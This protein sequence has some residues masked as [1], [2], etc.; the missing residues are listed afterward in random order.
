MK[1]LVLVLAMS[2]ASNALA[3]TNLYTIA[4]LTNVAGLSSNALFE[5][6]LGGA[7]SRH[8]SYGQLAAQI[9]TNLSTGG[10]SNL[11]AGQT[12]IADAT[13]GNDTTGTRGDLAKPWQTLRAVTNAQAGD[14][15]KLRPGAYVLTDP[16]TVPNGATIQGDGL[17]SST[18]TNRLARDMFAPFT[19][20]AA[21]VIGSHA[22][23]RDVTIVGE[24]YAGAPA[25]Y[26]LQ[27]APPIGF[28]GLPSGVDP[29]PATNFVLHSVRTLDGTT[30]LYLRHSNAWSGAI[31]DCEFRAKKTGATL[32]TGGDS[33]SNHL[34][35]F[36]TIFAAIGPNLNTNES[37]NY[38]ADGMKLTAAGTFYFQ[39]C[40][41]V[42]ANPRPV[43]VGGIPVGDP[44][45]NVTNATAAFLRNSNATIYFVG[46]TF[47]SQNTNTD[48]STSYDIFNDTNSTAGPA[49]VFLIGC[50]YDR[51]KVSGPVYDLTFSN[52]FAGS[53]SGVMFPSNITFTTS[54][55]SITDTNGAARLNANNGA[56]QLRVPKMDGTTDSIA[57]FITSSLTGTTKLQSW[58]TNTQIYTLL[59]NGNSNGVFILNPAG[60]GSG[61]T[62]TCDLTGGTGI[63]ITSAAN[64]RGGTI[65]TS[66]LGSGSTNV[67]I[68]WA[69]STNGL[70]TNFP[71]VAVDIT[72]GVY[73]MSVNHVCT[74][75]DNVGGVALVKVEVVGR[76]LLDAWTLNSGDHGILEWSPYALNASSWESGA[77]P[78]S[79]A[80]FFL[81][82]NTLAFNFSV[83]NANEEDSWAGYTQI[84]LER[85]ANLP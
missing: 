66:G 46:C 45:G 83:Q 57:V 32:F 44:A 47:E 27:N 69:H 38:A 64:G 51:T 8:I 23:I 53:F 65:S 43:P 12:L 15:V 16:V 24:A 28:F 60:D 22:E 77:P 35:A 39:N 13:S 50:R 61:L 58:D 11:P 30:G 6:S 29:S 82:T 72:A 3:G 85:K 70:G 56:M 5:V 49:N 41:F 10:L 14:V 67:V 71:S 42:G 34:F 21:V 37:G 48:G 19:N 36:N 54:T 80:V 9:S 84:V 1:R 63:T 74:N 52:D 68:A 17:P 4:N 2:V 40:Y 76:S 59:L 20:G 26:P 75:F 18:I 33:S 62:N 78:P 31:Y 73:Q 7:G 79:P 25:E 81:N 55:L